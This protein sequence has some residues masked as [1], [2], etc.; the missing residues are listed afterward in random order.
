[1]QRRDIEGEREIGGASV[2]EE[3]QLAI[4]DSLAKELTKMRTFEQRSEGA[5]K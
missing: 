3:R 4:L 5:R 1:M 2:G